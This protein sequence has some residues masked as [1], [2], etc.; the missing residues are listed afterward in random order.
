M[1]E[2]ASAAVIVDDESAAKVTDLGLQIKALEDALVKARF[3]KKRPYLV[4]LDLID[5]QYDPLIIPLVAARGDRM[6][7]LRG[8]L[9]AYIRKRDEAAV[10][11]VAKAAEEQRQ[12]EADAAEARRKADEA[13]QTGR[14]AVGA[15]LAALAAEDEADAAATR[16]QAVR[17]APIRSALGQVQTQRYIECEMEEAGLQPAV[18]WILEQPPLAAKLRTEILTIVKAYLRAL[19][20]NTV[21]EGVKIPGMKIWVSISAGSRR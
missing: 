17:P 12:R 5:S 3:E 1:I 10:A 8:M 13:R 11:A 21:A 18:L 6:T 14:G 2:L 9:T 4:A 15:E 7:G 20:V 16:A 19:G